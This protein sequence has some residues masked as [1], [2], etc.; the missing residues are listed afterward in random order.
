MMAWWKK[1]LLAFGLFFIWICG[2]IFIGSYGYTSQYFWVTGSVFAVTFGVSPFWRFRYSNWF[3]PTV[4]GLGL[5]HFFLLYLARDFV[6]ER[7]LPSKAMVQGLALID[8]VASWSMMVGTCW[9]S[10]RRLPWQQADQ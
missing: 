10:T 7:E 5:A 9:I 3:W 8:I 1:M 4:F 2:L 6:G